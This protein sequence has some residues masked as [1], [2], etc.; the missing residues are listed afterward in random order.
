M[1]SIRFLLAVVAVS[2]LQ[3]CIEVQAVP[4]PII[5]QHPR[6][7]NLSRVATYYSEGETSL[8]W[9]RAEGG[10]ERIPDISNVEAINLLL[11][12]LNGHIAT[13]SDKR[14]VVSRAKRQRIVREHKWILSRLSGILDS[15][16]PKAPND[17]REA[18]E[19]IKEIPDI[20][21][22]L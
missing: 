5:S 13:L 20:D 14:F 3:N 8:H 19:K 12:R 18:L 1:L 6:A 15:L 7:Q 9:R 11:S 16:D 10:D 17:V 22:L 4:R 2:F 21:G